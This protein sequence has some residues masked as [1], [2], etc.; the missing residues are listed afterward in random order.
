MVTKFKIFENKDDLIDILRK[1]AILYNS[2]SEMVTITKELLRLGE[3]TY[4]T[5]EYLENHPLEFNYYYFV[6]EYCFVRSEDKY[7]KSKLI[8]LSFYDFMKL[9][10]KKIKKIKHPDDPYDEEDWGWKFEE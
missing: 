4:R 3:T 1:S 10:S 2:H 8:Q 6:E 7:Y 9:V 5:V